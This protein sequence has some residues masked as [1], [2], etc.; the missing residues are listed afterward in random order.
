[1]TMSWKNGNNG[2]WKAGKECGSLGF[3]IEE[4][5]TDRV[6]YNQAKRD[7]HAKVDIRQ[8][9]HPKVDNRKPLSSNQDGRRFS[10]ERCRQGC[11]GC[12]FPGKPRT[13]F[14]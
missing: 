1:M 2:A 3:I 12:C 9:I 4:P 8:T 13:T 7:R 5:R 6:P 14:F 11:K 10:S